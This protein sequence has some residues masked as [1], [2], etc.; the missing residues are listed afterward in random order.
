MGL[1]LSCSHLHGENNSPQFAFYTDRFRKLACLRVV[2]FSICMYMSML[3][4]SAV[5]CGPHHW[6][7]LLYRYKVSAEVYRV[8]ILLISSS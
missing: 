8:A 7:Y 2:G 1:L 6:C 5:I 3:F 4:V